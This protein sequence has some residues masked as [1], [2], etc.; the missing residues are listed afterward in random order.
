MKKSVLFFGCLALG[1]LPLT[2]GASADK[3]AEDQ[4]FVNEAALGGK[5]EIELGTLAE[6]NGSNAEVKQ[7]GQQ[8]VTD[9]TRLNNELGDT[10]KKIGLQVPAELDSKQQAEISSLSKLSGKEFDARYSALMVKD[11]TDDLAAFQKAGAATQNE[12]LKKAIGDAVPVIQHHLEMA[13]M[14][15]QKVAGK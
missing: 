12:D 5:M 2:Y 3:S 11:H 6:K 4:H 1:T 15:Q 8:M 9:H 10:A 13:K 14:I 7:F